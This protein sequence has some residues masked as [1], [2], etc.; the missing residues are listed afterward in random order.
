MEYLKRPKFLKKIRFNHT[1]YSATQMNNCSIYTANTEF[2][3]TGLTDNHDLGIILFLVFLIFYIIAVLGNVGII[4]TIQLGADLQT[5]MYFFVSQLAMLDLFY[6]SIITPNTLVNFTRS[7]KTISISGCATQLLLFG[8]SATTESYILAAMA[9]DRLVAI[10]QPLL[11]VTIMS[12]TICRLLVVSAYFAGFLNSLIHISFIFSLKYW[13]ANVIDHFYCDIPPLFKLTCSDTFLNRVVI[14]LFG[15]LTSII[16]LSTILY[17][18]LNILLTILGIKSSKGRSKALSTCTSHL[19]C[20]SLFYSTLMLTYLRPPSEYL[21]MN[22]K[23]ISVFYT[24]VIPTV[25]PI[26][27]SLRNTDVKIAVKKIL[28]T[29][30]NAT[31]F[32]LDWGTKGPPV[33][34]ITLY[35][36]FSFSCELSLP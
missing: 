22:D 3:L 9:Y 28:R 15:G 33:Q 5:P 26:I 25:N 34:M 27:Y 11:Y 35:L 2:I 12:N 18:Y 23:I 10:R 8:G 30:V 29:D 1:A 14:L 17:S 21:Q 4:V 13:K 32:W 7:I 24:V 36:R 6:T 19:A 20:I 31:A 16:C